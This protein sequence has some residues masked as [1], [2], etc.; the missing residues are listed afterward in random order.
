MQDMKTWLSVLGKARHAFGDL[1]RMMRVGLEIA[2]LGAAIDIAYHL[3]TSAPTGHGAVA[4][5]G[6]LATLIGMIVTMVGLIA[7]AFKGRRNRASE[8]Q[9]GVAR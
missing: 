7:T 1:P 5:I 9:K 3:S 8:L 6:H 4:F 2:V